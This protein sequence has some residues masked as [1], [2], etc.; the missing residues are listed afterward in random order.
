MGVWR[1][2]KRFLSNLQNDNTKRS[3]TN[4][5][6]GKRLKK[7]GISKEILV[8]FDKVLRISRKINDMSLFLE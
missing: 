2:A 4:N 8:D 6:E 1:E 3:L 7:K 5:D